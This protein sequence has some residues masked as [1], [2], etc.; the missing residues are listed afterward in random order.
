MSTIILG[1][2]SSCDDTSAA[3]IKDG[4]LLSNV[5]ASQKVHEE[6]GGVVPELASRAHQQNIVPVVDTAIRRAGISPSDISAIAFTRG[7]GLLGS[8]LVG[9]SFAK[10]MAIGLGCRIVDVN[11]LHGHVLSHFIRNTVTDRVPEFPYLCLLIS[12]GNSQI[13]L[14]NSP[15]DMQVLGQTIDDAAGEAFDKCAKVMGLPYP[16]GPH[17]DRLSQEGDPKRFKFAKPHIPELDY[18][19]SGLKTSFLYT[20]R[21]NVKADPDFIENNK[22]DLAASLQATIIAILLDK[23]DKAVKITGVKTVAIGGGVSA[24]SGVRAAV[25]DYCA[26]HNLAA[27]IPERAFTTDN[28]AMVAIAGYFKYLDGDFC[29]M[30]AAPYARVSV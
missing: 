20:L 7:P 2:E 8:L 4:L 19:F 13:I 28:A 24:N 30:D 5:I 16:G 25:A 18:S 21:D 23:L 10:G 15:R 22:A 27:F 6:Y 3:V 14:V 17:I 1:I 9:T 12:G 26:S 11:H 29:A